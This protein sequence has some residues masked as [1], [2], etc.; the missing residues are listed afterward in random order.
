MNAFTS[1]GKKTELARRRSRPIPPFQTINNIRSDVDY[2]RGKANTQLLCD[3]IMNIWR[4]F[5]AT[6]KADP[7]E[8]YNDKGLFVCWGIKSDMVGG[9]PTLWRQTGRS[10]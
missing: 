8:L 9:L 3:H 7:I 10:A 6:V 2:L 1:S 5:G 4:Q